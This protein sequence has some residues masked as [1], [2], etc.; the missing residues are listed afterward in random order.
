M[1]TARA[2]TQQDMAD[3]RTLLAS[4]DP[5]GLAA[6]VAQVESA[7]AAVDAALAPTPGVL[8]DPLNALRQLT[9]ADVALDDALGSAREAQAQ[10]EHTK[11]TLDQA[12]LAAQSSLAAAADFISTRRGAIGSQART[13]LAEGQRHLDQAMSLSTTDPAAATREAQYAD[14]LG[15][16]ALQ[17][18]HNDV[19]RSAGGGAFG[20]EGGGFSGRGYG[21]RGGP[22][23]GSLILGG[24]LFGGGRGGGGGFGGGFSGG[25]RG[26]GRRSAGSFGG[27]GSRGRRGGGG[28]F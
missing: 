11:R 17:H 7:L 19:G 25:G 10:A 4:G 24:I 2:E 27:A 23:L 20:S 5:S 26:G 6:V 16:Q 13:R 18:A 8:P 9:E 1:T 12:M 21:G 14:A 28:R 15:Q 3:A 22:D